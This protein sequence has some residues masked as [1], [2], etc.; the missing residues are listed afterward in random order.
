MVAID[1]N[2][3]HTAAVAASNFHKMKGRTTVIDNNRAHIAI[4]VAIVGE[5]N[6][7]VNT[8]LR[9]RVT[10]ENRFRPDH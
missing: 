9:W 2:T 6:A 3:S 8:D 5:F 1:A 7:R 10:T 4:H